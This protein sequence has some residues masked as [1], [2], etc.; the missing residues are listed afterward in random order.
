MKE[1]VKRPFQKR[2]GARLS[3]FIEFDK[4]ALRP[5]PLSKYEIADVVFRRVGDNY[6]V[7][8]DGYY[9]S[10][11]FT[12]HKEQVVVRATNTVI[13]IVDKQH[14]R[15]ASHKRRYNAADGRYASTPDHMPPN[16]QAVY[17]QRQFDGNRYR[18]WAS[19]IG[20][21]TRFVIDA[22]LNAGKVEEQGYR[23]CMGIL[24]FTKTYSNERLEAACAKARDLS[25]YTYSTI[26]NILKNGAVNNQTNNQP[27][28]AHVNIRGSEYYS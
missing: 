16:H 26:K 5:L 2:E 10:V 21:N 28:P 18:S 12:L 17:K 4:P 25:S 23:S 22:V 14:I 1:I 20:E 3:N 8:Y 13:E 11:P 24:Q 27:T 7:E 6:H 19:S 15:V 9:Y